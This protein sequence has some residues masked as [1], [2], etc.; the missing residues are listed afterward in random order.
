I[1]DERAYR[2]CAAL[3]SEEGAS[4]F[5]VNVEDDLKIELLDGNDFKPASAL[6]TG[7]R[8]TAI[9]PII[10]AHDERPIILDQP[11]D[12][13]DNAFV[14]GTLVKSIAARSSSAQTII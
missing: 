7:Q 8:C 3:K 13:L 9:L 11:E 1:S 14:V 12:H 4:L 5:T 6:S 2:I 10:L